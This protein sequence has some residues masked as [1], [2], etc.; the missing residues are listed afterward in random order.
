MKIKPFILLLT[1]LLLL[2]PFT[3]V[4]AQAGEPPTPPQGDSIS[5]IADLLTS[6][7]L[8]RAGIVLFLVFGN[9]LAALL[10][11][12]SNNT[13]DSKKVPEFF[14]KTF[15]PFVGG[16]VLFE[17]AL[18]ILSP[19]MILDAFGTDASAQFATGFDASF[20]WV[21]FGSILVSVGRSFVGNLSALLS[22]IVA[23][24]KRLAALAVPPKPE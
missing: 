6:A 7:D 17:A 13:F 2:M 4:F 10:V 1:L 11:S 9:W 23:G 21:T 20:L 16:F 3:V 18:H 19:S 8:K 15:L 12:I 24:S 5:G 22:V 14:G